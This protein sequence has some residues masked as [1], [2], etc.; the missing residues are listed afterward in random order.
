MADARLRDEL[1]ALVHAV[2]RRLQAESRRRHPPPKQRGHAS[3][4]ATSHPTPGSERERACAPG[5]VR[6]VD[7]RAAVERARCGWTCFLSPEGVHTSVTGAHIVA[8][9][10]ANALEACVP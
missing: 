8:S 4:S 1:P 2:A 6:V 5:S 7:V 3:A 10:L 9:A